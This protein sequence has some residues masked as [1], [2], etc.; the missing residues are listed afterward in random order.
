[1]SYAEAGELKRVTVKVAVNGLFEAL[2]DIL[3]D[4][5]VVKD[6]CLSL[7]FIVCFILFLI[8]WFYPALM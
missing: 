3:G 5:P 1:M 7:V 4:M 2:L 6:V 8:L